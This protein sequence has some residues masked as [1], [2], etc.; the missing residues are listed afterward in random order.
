MKVRGRIVGHWGSVRRF[1]LYPMLIA[2]VLSMSLA[3]VANADQSSPEHNVG[4]PHLKHIFVIMM[5]NHSYADLMY[6]NDTPYIH[7]LARTYG[8]AT[9]YYGATHPTVPNRVGFWSGAGSHLTD[10]AKANTL[11]YPNL[12]DQLST[13]HISWGAYY[14][15]TE[16][17]TS[18]NPSYNYA[19]NSTLALFK[20]IANN[21][22]R[23]ANLHPLAQLTTA[24]QTGKGVPSFVY[25]GPNFI[26]N[27]H[28]SYGF[29]PTTGQYN[30]QGAGLGGGVGVGGVADTHLEAT[31]DQFLQTWVSRITHSKVWHSGPSAIFFAFD[32]NNYDA[33]MPQNYY[34]VS[35]QGV[36]GSPVY[37][38]GTN[39]SSSAYRFP[40]GVLGGG[41]SLALVITNVTG[42]VVSNQQY[43]E[44]SILRTIEAS[45]HLP[46]LG[47]AAA[48]GVISMAAFFHG[49]GPAAR[50]DS[51][52]QGVPV[53]GGYPEALQGTPIAEAVPPAAVTSATA[54]VAPMT[55]PY[56]ME[57]TSHQAAAPLQITEKQAGALANPLKIT[58][59]SPSSGVT[60][61]SGSVPVATTFVPSP[62]DSGTEFAPASVTGTAVTIPVHYQSTKVD[63]V[64]Y[65]TGLQLDVSGN[66]AAGPVQ[67]SVTSGSTALG[68][69]TIATVGRP[70]AGGTPVLLA[71]I[72]HSGSVAFPF[73]PAAGTP[74][75]DGYV[76]EIDGTNPATSSST[77]NEFF[78]GT[79]TV[80]GPLVANTLAGLTQ[81]G[82]KEYWVRVRSLSGNAP[83]SA[84]QTF[85]A[86]SLAQLP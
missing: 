59:T 74:A 23:M 71:P 43:N 24:L 30:F 66:V 60:F 19:S 8:L 53:G 21:P 29:T 34:Y 75:R 86:R 61:A 14:Q 39:L 12:I 41:R 77:S 67:A 62:K 45:W 51:G 25:I 17:S 81:L 52:S 49:G 35:N 55:D 40:G 48:P 27:M 82:G 7:Y 70:A 65:V 1:L 9:Q 54:V 32:E 56:L 63:S 42:H 57:F 36:A 33:S 18:A 10:G 64:A 79:T 84:A 46:Y 38:A 28:G 78:V 2:T 22:A 73:V 11:S 20:D 3:G 83:W 72:V 47:R 4:V 76:V 37:P 44:Y 69:V 85:T 58:I 5:E 80:S 15:H 50:Q 6:E 68:T 31:G 26:N 16:A 13:A